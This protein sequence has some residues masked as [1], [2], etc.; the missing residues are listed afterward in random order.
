MT[1]IYGVLSYQVSQRRREMGVRAALGARRGALIRLIVREGLAVTAAG[2]VVGLLAAAWLSRLIQGMLF[3]VDA[4]DPVTFAVA[5]AAL[6]A[7]AIIA[8]LVPANRAA[9]VDPIEALRCE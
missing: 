3:G 1:I 5:P 8:T 9:S 7:V 6:I 4:H 2:V